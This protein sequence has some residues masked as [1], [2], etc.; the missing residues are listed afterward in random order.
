MAAQHSSVGQPTTSDIVLLAERLWLSFLVNNPEFCN[1]V[2]TFDIVS[3]CEMKLD[4][5]D[6]IDFENYDFYIQK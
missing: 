3:F 2:S 5:F 1:F 4:K 6:V